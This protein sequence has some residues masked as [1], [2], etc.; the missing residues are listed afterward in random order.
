MV[1]LEPVGFDFP[2][3]WFVNCGIISNVLKGECHQRCGGSDRIYIPQNISCH[4]QKFG[5]SFYTFLKIYLEYDV[6][7]VGRKIFFISEEAI[8][9]HHKISFV[10]STSK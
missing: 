3:C 10:D 1:F 4:N 8:S 5:K 2:C 7:H 9:E 6:I